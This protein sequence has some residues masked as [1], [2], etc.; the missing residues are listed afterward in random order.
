MMELEQKY[1]KNAGRFDEDCRKAIK[2][3]NEAR[4]KC[5]IRDTRAHKEEFIKR[6]NEARKICRDKRREMINNE[7]KELEVEN[8]T[9]EIESFTRNWKH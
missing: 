9:N 2:A 1:T 8:R 3:K 4:K 7:I 5:V 6:R